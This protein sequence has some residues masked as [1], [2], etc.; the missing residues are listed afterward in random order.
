[1]RRLHNHAVVLAALSLL[2]SCAV[3]VKTTEVPAVATL[4]SADLDGMTRT[5][6]EILMGG[7]QSKGVHIVEGRSLDM[8][9]YFGMKGVM[10]LFPSQG[11]QI[12][13]GMAFASFDEDERLEEIVF[14]RSRFDG[15]EIKIGGVLP[16]AKVAD[17]VTLGQTSIAQLE[18]LLGTP[19]YR[20]SRFNAASGVR[21]SLSFFEASKAESSG[22]LRERWLLAGHDESGVVQDL[23]W[24]SSF[25]EDM[26]SLGEVAPQSLM[27]MTK[28]D[29]S[30]PLPVVR[31]DSVSS[32]T[33]I[34]PVQVEAIIRTA[35]T[36]I[37]GY[38]DVLGKPTAVGFKAFSEHEPWLL[39]HW[40]YMQSEYLGNEKLPPMEPSAD[41]REARP[42]SFMVLD[43]Q[44]TRLMVAHTPDG[45]VREVIWLRPG[46][47]EPNT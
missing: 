31:A 16:V 47:G 21:H 25:P 30:F 22:L 5:Q 36:S 26:K 6:F 27:A 11:A 9:Y 42:K 13:S 3:L 14:V 45:A 17:H 19:S 7:A 8:L 1:M 4:E 34:D 40:S 35:P 33:K 43:I 37:D 12:D 28:L 38:I 20:G 41:G 46:D 15:P 2:G 44:T 18:E 32:S 24:A 23:L 10:T 39:S 29:V